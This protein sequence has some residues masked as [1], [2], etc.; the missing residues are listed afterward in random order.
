MRAIKVMFVC[1]I[2]GEEPRIQLFHGNYCFR[3]PCSEL[4]KIQ[5]IGGLNL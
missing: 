2:K 3:K 5:S 1:R 4:M